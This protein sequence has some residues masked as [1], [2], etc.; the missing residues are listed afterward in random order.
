MSPR[1]CGTRATLTPGIPLTTITAAP[2][3]VSAAPTASRRVSRSPRTRGENRIS[4]TGSTV[5][6]SA[7][8]VAV[9]WAIPQLPKA[10]AAAKPINPIQK[11]FQRSARDKRTPSRRWASAAG[12]STSEPMRRRRSA[13]VA[14]PM[15]SSAI[16]LT[17]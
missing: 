9:E 16:R 14:G 10:N 13:S 1:Q 5:I 8:F 15:Y 12:T 6:S 4:A 2:S 7:A 17:T 11:M 3:T